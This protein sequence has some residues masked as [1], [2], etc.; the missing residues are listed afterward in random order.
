M[1][2]AQGASSTSWDRA[3]DNDIH[4]EGAREGLSDS[5]EQ[6]HD[7]VSRDIPRTEQKFKGFGIGLNRSKRKRNRRKESRRNKNKNKFVKIVGVNAAGILNKLDSFENLIRS[8]EP[9]IFCLQETKA[10]KENQIKT[11]STKRYTIYELLRK[12]SNGGGLCV[13][14]LKDLQPCWLSQGDDEVEFITIEV[15]IDDFPIRVL[16]AYG[17]QLGDSKERKDKFWESIETEV[18]NAEVA[19]AGFILQMDS[20]CHLGKDIIKDDVNAQN[21]NG[22]LFMK[23]MERNPSLTIINSLQLCEGTIT[24]MRKTTRGVEK[25]V[26]D[27]FVACDKILPYIE[28]MKV[29]EKRESGLTNFKAVK[30]IGRVVESDHN[31]VI[32]E[33]KLSFSAIKPERIEV[34]QFKDKIAQA[35]FQKLT[36]DT[37]DFTDCFKNDFDFEV[38]AANWR[39][40]LNNYFHKAFK[41]VRVTNK[42]IKKGSEVLELIEKRKVLKKKD[43]L[44]EADE[45]EIVRLEALVAEK[46]QD[47]NRQKVVDNF[48]DLGGND[49]NLQHQGIWKIKRKVFPKIKPSLPVG[50]KNIK[51]QLITNP[52]ELK[53]LYLDTFKYRLRHR[54]V[55]PGFESLLDDLEEL[56]KERLDMSKNVKTKDWTMEDL[57]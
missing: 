31:P 53:K 46:C 38:Q 42:P 48:C 28:R 23:F 39:K 29:D 37:N 15:W 32:M 18:K 49:G 22:K 55:Q 12:N 26:L 3:Q 34:F 47:T 13:G 21:S 35:E 33:L 4:T 1:G 17:P 56:F 44:S 19:G 16:N 43:K 8:E 52:E 51:N 10:K 14:V 45:E 27:V 40:M 5:D 30:K 11:E 57:D 24:R 20:N 50:K 54:P 6:N 9:S 25:S 2:S 36:T 41:K 7:E